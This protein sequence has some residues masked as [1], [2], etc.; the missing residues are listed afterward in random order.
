VP[1]EAITAASSSRGVKTGTRVLAKSA[2]LRVTTA[3]AADA[4]AAS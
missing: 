3:A 2:V 1:D 4:W